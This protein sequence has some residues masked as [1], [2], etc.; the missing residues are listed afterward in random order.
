MVADRI[1]VASEIVL[2]VGW[3]ERVF[4]SFGGVG[5]L[6]PRENCSVITSSNNFLRGITYCCLEASALAYRI[7]VRTFF[8]DV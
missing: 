3:Q 2:M 8:F 5:K 6:A 4:S 1:A 7:G